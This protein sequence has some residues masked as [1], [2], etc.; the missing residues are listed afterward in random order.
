MTVGQHQV[1]AHTQQH[2]L[3]ADRGQVPFGQSMLRV[4]KIL[5]AV[6]FGQEDAFAEAINKQFRCARL[7]ATNEVAWQPNTRHGQ[8]QPPGDK[9]IHRTKANRTAAASVDDLIQITAFSL[10]AALLVTLEAEV[11]E[12]KAVN[13][14]QC[15]L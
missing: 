5:N 11:L 14:G 9:K 6:S 4:Q 12:K 8:P 7:I 15:L 3:R 2:P 1:I 10:V 13:A